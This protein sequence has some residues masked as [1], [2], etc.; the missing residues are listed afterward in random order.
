LALLGV[1]LIG[2]GTVLRKIVSAE[3]SELR[4]SEFGPRSSYGCHSVCQDFKIICMNQEH[5]ACVEHKEICVKAET[6][7]DLINGK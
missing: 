2:G 7:C 6:K 3:A 5:G 4:T 1:A